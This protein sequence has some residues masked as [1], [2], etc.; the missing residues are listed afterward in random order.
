MPAKASLRRV[1]MRQPDLFRLL[2]RRK[3]SQMFER[4]VVRR[5]DDL[6]IEG[7]PRSGN[8][9]G[10]AA[11]RMA[12]GA[13]V[14]KIGNHFH[15]PAQILLAA[16]YGIPALVVLRA[17]HAACLSLVTYSQGRLTATQALQDYIAF[18]APLMARQDT[19]VPAP[20]EAV[21]RDFAPV[22]QRLNRRFNTD[23]A[24]YHNSTDADD[25]VRA[26]VEAKRLAR[27]RSDAD[28]TASEAR[29]TTPS[30]QKAA[31]RAK[32]AADFDRPEAQALRAQADALYTRLMDHPSLKEDI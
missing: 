32:Y 23:F 8:T 29:K 27:I 25:A 6:V 10:T 4:R 7:F 30:A 12:Q 11:F 19:F 28:R 9:F 16:R 24:P 17:P 20:F 2:W 18:H 15:A 13:R 31:L 5:G 3:E 22:I 14:L 1:L 26:Q 21:T